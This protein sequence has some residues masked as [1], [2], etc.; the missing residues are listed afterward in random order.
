[1]L[2]AKTAEGVRVAITG[3][4]ASVFR[5]TEMEQV[6]NDNFS[7]EAL[8]EVR[9]ASDDMNADIHAGA[10]YRAHLCGVMAAQ[11]VALI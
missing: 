11:A 8:A 3:A 9:L 1:V 4:A 6:L 5:A 7:V 2:V 10:E